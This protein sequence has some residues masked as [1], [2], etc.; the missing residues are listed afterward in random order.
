[1]RYNSPKKVKEAINQIAVTEP[2]Y[3]IIAHQI[4]DQ[5]LAEIAKRNHQD[6]K[7]FKQNYA[8]KK[9]STCL[10]GHF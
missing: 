8:T 3:R 9:V 10:C 1:M 2:L 5:R 6:L 7:K 4:S